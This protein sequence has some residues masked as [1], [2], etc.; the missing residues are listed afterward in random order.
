MDTVF[1]EFDYR[2]RDG[3]IVHIRAMTLSDEAAILRGFERMRPEDR[4]MRFMRVV[5]EPNI[6]R[7]RQVLASFPEKGLGI[8]ATLGPDAGAEIVGSAMFRLGSEPGRCEFATTVLAD[9]GG[10]G[11]GRGL[12]TALIQ[13]AK[14]RGLTEMEGYVLAQ[15]RPMLSLAKRLGFSVAPDPEDSSARICHLHLADFI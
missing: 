6:T 4:Y 9:Y 5:G 7:L 11:L 2:L 10:Q 1:H 15:N 13:A 3:R 8:V 12:M 14:R